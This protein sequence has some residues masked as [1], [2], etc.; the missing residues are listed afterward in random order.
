MSPEVVKKLKLKLLNW[1]SELFIIID[2]VLSEGLS[3]QDVSNG[4]LDSPK[5]L[6]LEL[7]MKFDQDGLH[8]VLWSCKSLILH[9]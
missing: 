1:I 4:A 6:L 5:E 7:W 9:T 3:G 2:N 8:F